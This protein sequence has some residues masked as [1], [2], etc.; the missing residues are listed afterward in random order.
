[1]TETIYWYDFETTGT[2]PVSDRP[3]QFAGVRTDYDLQVV[4]DESNF[5]CRPGNDVIPN[6]DA[7]L[8]T[9]ILMGEVD[10]R[11]LIEREFTKKVLAE[12]AVPETCVAGFNNIR[13]DDEFTRH[14]LYRNFHDPYAREWQSG[15]S[16]W[17]IIDVLRTAYALRPE[18]IEWPVREDGSPSFRLEDL[19]SA[20]EIDHGRAHDAL[21]DVYATIEIT[22]LLRR[23]QPRLYDFMF[24]L[25]DRKAVLQQLYPLR[26]SAMVH[27]SSMYSASKGCT[28][29]VLPLCRHPTNTNGII[30]FD[31][32]SSPAELL[33]VNPQELARLLFTSSAELGEEEERIALKTIHINRCPA[34]APLVTLRDEDAARLS[35]DKSLCEEHMRQLQRAGGIVEK[36]QEVY[37]GSRFEESDDP[38]FL[39]YQGGFFPDSDRSLMLELTESGPERLSSFEGRFQDDR[40]DEMLFRYRARNFPESLDD[41]ER[42]RWNRYRW[43]NWKEGAVIDEVKARIKTILEDE[44]TASKDIE[45]MRDLSAYIDRITSG[46]SS[47]S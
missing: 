13:F 38:D 12:F 16:R 47:T 10:K 30:C 21:A 19:T 8:V 4:G 46:V 20:N 3:L 43:L 11:G 36:I 37:S 26:K 34:I 22:R 5:V 33:R 18:G 15:N 1:M 40:A 28:A 32:S 23:K 42:N 31:L 7:L 14:L 41:E 17:D 35:L 9:G 25:R 29:V 24:R 6:P 2:D 45:S 39:L 44:Q 27:V